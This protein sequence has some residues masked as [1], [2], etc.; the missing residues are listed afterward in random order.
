MS[1]LACIF[2]KIAAKQIPSTIVHEDEH[3]VAHP[4]RAVGA[5]QRAGWPPAG[6]QGTGGAHRPGGAEARPGDGHRGERLPAGGQLRTGCGP[7]GVPSSL[8][9]PGG[10]AHGGEDG[11]KTRNGLIWDLKF[12]DD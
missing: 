9:P 11:L 3:V 5:H 7:D 10:L 2:C 8:P 1:E 6:P 12:P 4:H